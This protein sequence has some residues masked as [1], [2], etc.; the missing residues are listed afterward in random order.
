MSDTHPTFGQPV[1]HR[2]MP[3]PENPVVIGKP[4]HA[5]LAFRPSYNF[6]SVAPLVDAEAERS[7][8]ADH[9]LRQR[10]KGDW[11]LNQANTAL[12]NACCQRTPDLARG[13]IDRAVVMRQALAVAIAAIDAGIADVCG[14]LGLAEPQPNARKADVKHGSRHVRRPL[15][16][17]E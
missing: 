17:G 10:L 11:F 9:S 3:S 15:G 6:P 5:E 4:I 13:Q 12:G 14:K 2:V 16:P 1:T 8:F 7:G